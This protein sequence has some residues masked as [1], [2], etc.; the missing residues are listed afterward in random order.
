MIC[1]LQ[2]MKKRRWRFFAQDVYTWMRGGSW[3]SDGKFLFLLS[4][5]IILGEMG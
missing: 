5:L 1:M 4:M 2:N 3:G